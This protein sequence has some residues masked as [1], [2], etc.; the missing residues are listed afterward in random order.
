MEDLS[1]MAHGAGGGAR[2]AQGG[3]GGGGGHE[4]DS[5][6]HT[7]VSSCNTPPVGCSSRASLTDLTK[8]AA[9]G[10]ASSNQP[11]TQTISAERVRDRVGQNVQKL[12]DSTF[13]KN[14]FTVFLIR[15]YD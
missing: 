9:S 13:G 1:G 3:G 7:V 12:D 14:S 2:P 8:A 15:Y 4:D 5:T 11:Q 10:L 6:K